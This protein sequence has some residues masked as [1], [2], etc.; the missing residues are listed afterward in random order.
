VDY[1]YLTEVTKI[2]PEVVE[3]LEEAGTLILFEEGAPPELAEMSVLHEHTE[4][5]DEPPEVGDTMVIGDREFRITAIGESAWK[6]MLQLGHASFK[7]NGAQEVELPGEICLEGA[8]SENIVES[9]QPGTRMEIK[10]TS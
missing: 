6:N 4:R 10:A 1:I 2:G 3:L 7:F 9:I 5:R 8:G